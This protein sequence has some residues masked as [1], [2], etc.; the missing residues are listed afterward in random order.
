MRF[1]VLMKLLPPP[2]THIIQVFRKKV[3]VVV[4]EV[5]FKAHQITKSFEIIYHIDCNKF[6][7]WRFHNLGHKLLKN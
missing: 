1:Y 5:D 3:K 7:D 6:I 2:F 4:Q